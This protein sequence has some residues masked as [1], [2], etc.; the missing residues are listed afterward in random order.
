[1]ALTNTDKLPTY[2]V[3]YANGERHGSYM[4]K[5]HADEVADRLKRKG[6]TVKV[7]RAI[8]GFVD[9]SKKPMQENQ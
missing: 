2:H 9:Q 7:K 5:E 1:M 6:Q 3:D 8:A 4:T